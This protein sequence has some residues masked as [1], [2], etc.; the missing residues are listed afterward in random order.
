M[1]R[2]RPGQ[3]S[4]PTTLGKEKQSRTARC[5]AANVEQFD[6]VY[7]WCQMDHLYTLRAAVYRTLCNGTGAV[8]ARVHRSEG[9][10][11]H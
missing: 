11:A 10:F 8:A 5:Q 9:G 6:D 2:S 3:G 4:W 1:G 7:T